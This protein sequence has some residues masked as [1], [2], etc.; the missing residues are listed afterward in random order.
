MIDVIISE[1]CKKRISKIQKKM[2]WGDGELSGP[3]F[4]HFDLVNKKKILIVEQFFDR[5]VSSSLTNTEF[6]FSDDSTIRKQIKKGDKWIGTLHTHPFMK[7]KP[8][9]TDLNTSQRIYDKLGLQMA[10][11]MIVGK[12][13]IYMWK[14]TNETTKHKNKKRK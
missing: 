12:E 7:L 9:M 14:E 8:S 3:L 10:V 11:F 2:T 5:T 6:K 1:K 4:G 13:E